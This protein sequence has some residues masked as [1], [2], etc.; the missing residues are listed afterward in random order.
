MK[1]SGLMVLGVASL[2]LL[3]A[4]SP[5]A[6]DYP[7]FTSVAGLKLN[8]DAAKVGKVLRL[9]PGGSDRTGS[10][11]TT[12]PVVKVGKSFK[13]Q[14]TLSTHDGD[15]PAADGA[16]FVLLNGPKTSLGAG[17]QGLGYTGLTPSFEL[18]FD[19]YQNPESNDPNDN[20]IALMKDG[21]PTAHLDTFS[22]SYDIYGSKLRVWMNYVAKSHTTKVW[23]TNK[24]TKPKQPVLKLQKKLTNLLHA[25]KARAG[26]TAATGGLDMVADVLRWKLTQ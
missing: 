9:V 18:E 3:A 16:A 13:T 2:L 17:G 4:S 1:R 6:V 10:A 5:G 25:E 24:K 26:F 12:K 23:V 19:L 21:D 14:F 22:P 8:A 7:D 15:V 20:H 11:F